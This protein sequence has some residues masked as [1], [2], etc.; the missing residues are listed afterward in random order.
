MLSVSVFV[1]VFFSLFYN[2]VRR[3]GAVLFPKSLDLMLSPL[4]LIIFSGLVIS[5]F[6]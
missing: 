3:N 6:V 4:F 5:N 2:F 1:N